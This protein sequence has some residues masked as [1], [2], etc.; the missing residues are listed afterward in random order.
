MT[1]TVTPHRSRS[2]LRCLRARP[3]GDRSSIARGTSGPA[4]STPCGHSE[5]PGAN[6][7][8]A[9]R[10]GTS[11]AVDSVAWPSATATIHGGGRGT[12]G[13]ALPRTTNTPLP[14]G[15]H[16]RT[17]GG[18][19]F[20]SSVSA[21][22]AGAPAAIAIRCRRHALALARERSQ[23]SLPAV[24]RSDLP[25]LAVRS[26]RLFLRSDGRPL[27]QLQRDGGIAR[28]SACL[29]DAGKRCRRSPRLT[30]AKLARGERSAQLA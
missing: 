16:G 20:S 11:L 3:A 18:V 6:I 23:Y 17:Y 24:W 28:L 15:R 8:G 27:G 10:R 22:I 21:T 7:E 12:A 13:T 29:A 14:D 30:A 4:D 5:R 9:S 2:V 25:G 26:G 1:P 19:R